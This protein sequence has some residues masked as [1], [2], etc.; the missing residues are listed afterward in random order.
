MKVVLSDEV[1]QRFAGLE[2]H[3]S[4]IGIYACDPEC[5]FVFSPI[6][7]P[8]LQELHGFSPTDTHPKSEWRPVSKVSNLESMRKFIKLVKIRVARNLKGFPFCPQMTQKDFEKVE[9]YLVMILG[10]MTGKVD[11]NLT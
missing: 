11:L 9:D 8:I 4:K 2:I 5:Y 3:N 7:F 1:P 10:L 6:F